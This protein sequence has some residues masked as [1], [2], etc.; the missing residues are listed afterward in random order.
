MHDTPNVCILEQSSKASFRPLLSKL[1]ILRVGMHMHIGGSRVSAGVD[2]SI[3]TPLHVAACVIAVD[4]IC[5]GTF[6]WSRKTVPS[7][8][9]MACS[10]Y[11]VTQHVLRVDTRWQAASTAYGITM[12]NK[13]RTR[14]TNYLAE[15]TCLHQLVDQVDLCLPRSMFALDSDSAAKDCRNEASSIIANLQDRD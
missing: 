2:F 9:F 11:G 13:C 12:H 6:G 10:H 14:L 3:S 7:Y 15:Q 5:L 1:P 8:R 4:N